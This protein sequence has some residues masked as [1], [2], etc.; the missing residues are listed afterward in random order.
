[1]SQ[2]HKRRVARLDLGRD[3]RLPNACGCGCL[4]SCR[5]TL[6]VVVCSTHEHDAW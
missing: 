3:P 5:N 4:H 6:L 1:V 2:S